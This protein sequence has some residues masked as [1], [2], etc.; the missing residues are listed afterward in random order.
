MQAGA[1]AAI[2]AGAQEAGDGQH[3]IS[4]GSIALKA[5]DST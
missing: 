1:H 2:G 4:L 3:P 5:G